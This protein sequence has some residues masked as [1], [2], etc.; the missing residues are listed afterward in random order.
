MCRKVETATL[1]QW[2]CMSTYKPLKMRYCQLV[3]C[4]LACYYGGNFRACPK[5]ERKILCSVFSRMIVAAL[6]S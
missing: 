1:F 5:L 3:R 2:H 6:K 4:L